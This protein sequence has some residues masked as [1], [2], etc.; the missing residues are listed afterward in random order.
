MKLFLS[1]FSAFE[2]WTALRLGAQPRFKP[3]RAVTLEQCAHTN[4]DVLAFA[5]R[6]DM[7]Q[8]SWPIDVLIPQTAN[9]LKTSLVIPPSPSCAIAQRR[10]PL[11]RAQFVRIVA[12]ALLPSACAR[13]TVARS[14][15][16][17]IR[18]LRHVRTRPS[19]RLRARAMQPRHHE[20]EAPEVPRVEPRGNRDQTS[21]PR[22]AA[23]IGQLALSH[24]VESRTPPERKQPHRRFRAPRARAQHRAGH[25]GARMQPKSRQ[26]H[27]KRT[28]RFPNTRMRPPV[29]RARRR[30][31]VRQLGAPR[32]ERKHR[33]RCEKA[34]PAGFER[35]CHPHH[36]EAAGPRLLRNGVR[37]IGCAR[38]AWKKSQ[39]S[40]PRRAR[41]AMEAPSHAVWNFRITCT[42]R[43]G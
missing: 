8:L 26:C 41:S 16:H 5:Q 38:A 20:N 2:Y 35:P 15:A 11:G 42:A 40:K 27:D 24:G 14:C 34:Q 30:N 3:A 12:R 10:V 7:G 23:C 1:G 32:R 25:A 6:P 28:S 36:H 19:K 33:P 13:R 43:A 37:C 22:C 21:P 29:A 18:A 17:R 4:R 9:N 39:A 31:R